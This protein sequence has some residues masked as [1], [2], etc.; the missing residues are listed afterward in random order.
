M[1]PT[2]TR[3]PTLPKSNPASFRQ[4]SKGALVREYKSSQICSS[5]DLERLIFRCFGP[6]ASAVM[7]GRFMS[8][9]WEEDRAIFAFSASSFSLCMAIGSPDKSIPW[10]F[11]NSS[12]NQRIICS[13]QLSPP[14]WVSPLV[15]FTSKTP[16][17]ISKTLISNVPP[18]KS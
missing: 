5:F 8:V 12:I 11:L 1:P 9:D 4:D 3:L 15:A 17:A 6:D 18:P 7:K 16:S 14:N 10:S 13:S 2:R